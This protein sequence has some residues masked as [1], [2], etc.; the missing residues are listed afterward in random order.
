[1]GA[2]PDL[3]VAFLGTGA[4]AVPSLRAVHA[5]GHDV[6]LVVSQPDRPHGRG[7]AVTPTPVKEAALELGVKVFQPEKLRLDFATLVEASPDILVVVAYGQILRAPVLDLAPRG[8]VNVHASLLPTYRGAA[9]I[10]WAIANG[11][12]ETGVT[13][14][15]LDL[16]MDTGPILLQKRCPID[17]S[18]TTATL[19]PRL[20]ELGAQLL[21]Q[22]LDR[23]A[24]GRIEPQPQD[25]ARATKA[26]LIKKTD[27]FVDFFAASTIVNRLRGFTP[28]PGVS[29]K[30][31]PRTLQLTQARV[32]QA[33]PSLPSTPPQAGTVISIRD[34]IAVSC[35]DGSILE[36]QR[37]KPES[38][39]VMSATDFARGARMAVGD[40]FES[41]R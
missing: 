4:F 16:G 27:G 3:K 18:D 14:M 17:A 28:W 23:L 38:R 10:Q 8:A 36:I 19:E 5:A 34:T 35:A 33:E 25:E 41:L 15:Q 39:G 7:L 40:R 9:P 30:F 20:A 12:N 24:D 1:M 13:T 6:A 21:I 2:G 37:V 31:G 29:L 11:E 32:A 22:T 26:P